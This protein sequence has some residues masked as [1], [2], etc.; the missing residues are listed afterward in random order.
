M[1]KYSYIY[2]LVSMIQGI[3]EYTDSIQQTLFEYLLCLRY[4]A[5]ENKTQYLVSGNIKSR[6]LTAMHTTQTN[7]EHDVKDGIRKSTEKSKQNHR[8]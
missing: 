6:E 7:V 4:C 3:K 8:D 2:C 5:R 1:K